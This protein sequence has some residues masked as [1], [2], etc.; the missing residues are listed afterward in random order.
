MKHTLVGVLCIF[1]VSC[2]ETKTET[3]Q[4]PPPS[5]KETLAGT[6]QLASVSAP[7][8]KPVAA[9]DA[10]LREAKDRELVTNGLLYSFFPDS[11]FT[12]ISGTGEYAQDKWHY[13]NKG[14]FIC[15]VSKKD[16]FLVTFQTDRGRQSLRLEN[17][18]KGMV[19]NFV[20]SVD[21]L[22]AYQEDPFHPENNTWRI[23]AVKSEG[24]EE[25]HARL[26]NYFRHLAYLLKAATERNQPSIS[27]VYS[28]GPV[29]IYNGGIGRLP[30]MP[31]SWV[32]TYYNAK[33]ATT[34][35][36]MFGRYLQT[37]TYE[38]V[39][40]GNWYKDDCAILTRIYGDI[41]EGKF[42]KSVK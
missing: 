24:T 42:P 31:D 13:A 29:Q 16:T 38:G 33:E 39:N 2:N 36:E 17:R 5:K 37:S 22:K 27:F 32:N 9:D 12:A 4:A 26:G 7:P 28:Q 14:K 6:W 1:L 19:M 41:K 30:T 11:S 25:L 15:L 8:D 35:Y 21:A 23:K 34:A 40:T 20:K 10:L 18:G 3:S